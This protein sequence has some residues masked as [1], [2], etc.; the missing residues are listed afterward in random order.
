MKTTV[1]DIVMGIL[2][3]ILT[4]VAEFIVTLPFGTPGD[5]DSA[6]L[7]KFINREL[8]LTALPAGLVT[9]VFAHLL[10]T[11]TQQVALRRSITWT[12]MI[13]L[14]FLLIGIGNQ[15]LAQIFGTPGIYALLAFAFAGPLVYSWVTSRKKN[16]P[17]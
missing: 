3:I 9:F 11:T 14:N 15:N 10:K 5:I 13:L 7:T 2:I 16:A 6:T 17:E 8:L 1:K 4:T 12:V